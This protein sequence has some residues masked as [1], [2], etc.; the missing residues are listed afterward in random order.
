MSA[1]LRNYYDTTEA[2]ME[3]IS[4]DIADWSR[5]RSQQFWDPSRKLLAVIRSYQWWRSKSGLFP[6]LVCKILVLRHR[7]WSVVT[8]ADIPL[9]CQI[10]GGLLL[11]HPNGV[12]IHPRAVIGVNCLIF[13]QVTIGSRSGDGLPIVGGHVDIGAGAK[14][15]GKVTIGDHA[16]I[17]A[18][19]VVTRN[20]PTHG[21][22][23]GFS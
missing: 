10:G 17:G 4:A 19:A 18:N 5:E 21:T 1:N 23:T 11:P 12:V 13:Q 2:A 6:L 8:G 3:T 15:L 7:F 9:N 22:A 16:R 20:V 14:I